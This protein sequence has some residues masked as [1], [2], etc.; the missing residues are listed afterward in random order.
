MSSQREVL[1]QKLERS[2]YSAGEFIEALTGQFAELLSEMEMAK[3]VVSTHVSNKKLLDALKGIP[4]QPNCSWFRNVNQI[5]LTTNCYRMKTDKLISLV[6]SYD[7]AEKQKA[8]GNT[9]AAPC[10]STPVVPSAPKPAVV[11]SS[12]PADSL[13][14]S[15]S[16]YGAGFQ[17]HEFTPTP[18]EECVDNICCTTSC[19]EKVSGYKE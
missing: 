10:S 17:I 11:C 16:S 19:R 8:Q 1:E 3:I 14:N 9:Y 6:K 15:E 18:T 5:I 7:T 12:T 2:R 4:D 13:Q